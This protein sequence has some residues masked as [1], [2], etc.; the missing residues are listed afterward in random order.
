MHCSNWFGNK[1][2]YRGTNWVIFT[3]VSQL[4]QQQLWSDEETLN[5]VSFTVSNINEI[6]MC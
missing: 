3:F 6:K 5:R 1:L 4:D 2:T